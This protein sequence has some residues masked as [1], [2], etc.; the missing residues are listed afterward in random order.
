MSNELFISCIIIN[1]MMKLHCIRYD[2]KTMY[3][4]ILIISKKKRL[5]MMNYEAANVLIF[6]R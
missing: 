4:L 6:P 5:N 2:S 3:D 1:F